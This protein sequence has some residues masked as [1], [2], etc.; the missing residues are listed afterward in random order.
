MFRRILITGAA[1]ALGQV[2][3]KGVRGQAEVLRLSDRVPI[4]PAGD[5]EEVA[6]CD[7][8]DAGAV[9]AACEGVDAILHFGAQPDEGDWPV[10][11]DANIRGA[12]NLWEGARQAKV[13]R[14]I[15]AS[16][17]HAIGL[18]RRS[19]RLDHRT[20]PRCDSR[21]G[22]SKAFGEE[23]AQLYAYKHGI[24]AMCLRIGTCVPEPIN[25]RALST[26]LSY[27]DL[28]RLVGVGLTADYVFEIVYGV[29]AN[30]RSWWDNSNAH[31]LGYRPQDNA[32]SHAARLEGLRFDDPVAEAMQGGVFA[33]DE[34][35]GRVDWIP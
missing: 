3:R 24:R 12:I 10:V 28:V 2:L 23:L 17:N 1:G 32:E 16:S 35:T 27:G 34:F 11:L 31:R 33:A 20:P 8:A 26:W 4:T 19:E 13:E 5:C 7:L 29:S 30:T 18:H 25:A 6:C 15:F 22:L 9:A 14:I 21:Y